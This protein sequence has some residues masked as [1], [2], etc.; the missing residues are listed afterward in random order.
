MT[1]CELCGK[2]IAGDVLRHRPPPGRAFCRPCSERI[3]A[4]LEAVGWETSTP[5]PP[6]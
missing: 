1:V 6:G 2:P 5:F 3:E 4:A